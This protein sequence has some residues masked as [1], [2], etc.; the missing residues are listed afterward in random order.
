MKT[1][2]QIGQPITALNGKNPVKV[3]QHSKQYEKVLTP[4][5]YNGIVMDFDTLKKGKVYRDKIHEHIYILGAKTIWQI[6]EVPAS[7]L[8]PIFQEILGSFGIS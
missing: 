4:F 3:I 2:K 5:I 7:N 8:H 1:Y 6:E